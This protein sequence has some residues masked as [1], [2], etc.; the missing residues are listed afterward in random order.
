MDFG[1]S[2]EQNQLQHSIRQFL[3]AEN[4]PNKLRARF[5]SDQDFDEAFWRGMVELGLGGLLISEAHDGAGLELLD[6]ALTAEVLGE[7]AAPG[8]FIFHTLAGLAI[9]LG[10]SDAQKQAWLAKLATGEALGTVAFAEGG[11][12]WLPEQWTLKG[13]AL[14][15]DKLLVPFA[16]HADVIVVGC[17]GGGLALVTPGASGLAIEPFGGID[18]TRRSATLHFD[19]TP[20]EPMPGGP[21]VAQRVCDAGLVLLAADAFGGAHRCVE[22]SVAYAGTREQFGVSIAHFQ[23]YKHQLANMVLDVEPARALYWYAAHAFDHAPEEARRM[24]ALAKA[25]LG[26]RYMQT[27]RDAVEAHGGIGFT[28]ECD[29]QIWFKRALFDHT[30]LGTPERH[31]ERAAQL[32]GW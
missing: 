4:D 10:G 25:H 1:L 9:E 13:E 14:S 8:P 31:R 3:A 30:W 6:A 12:A 21:E 17:A 19:K 28:W 7:G 15:G 18:R 11:G 32:A 27:A 2:E 26:A 16:P 24:A 22:M 23:A 20:A 29:V 5:D